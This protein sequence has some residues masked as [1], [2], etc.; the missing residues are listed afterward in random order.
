MSLTNDCSK[1]IFPKVTL[2]FSSE[3][4]SISSSLLSKN[5]LPNVFL[6]MIEFYHLSQI[7]VILAS[8]IWL[9]LIYFIMVFLM[10]FT[11]HFLEYCI[12]FILIFM[13][14]LKRNM[15][16]Y[17]SPLFASKAFYKNVYNSLFIQ[18]ILIYLALLNFESV[19]EFFFNIEKIF[20]A[21]YF[22]LYHFVFQ[23]IWVIY[24]CVSL[25][26]RVQKR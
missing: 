7:I 2:L 22:Q 14:L 18:H 6:L 1:Y 23:T 16:K 19:Q 9:M 20:V 13:N 21:F 26:I 15:F 3:W 11:L 24:K 10:E 5:I 12:I 17:F 8:K 25:K 4:M